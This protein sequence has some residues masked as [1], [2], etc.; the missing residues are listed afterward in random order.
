MP[1][2]EFNVF[3]GHTMLPITA[4]DLHSVRDEDLLQVIERLD[5]S[6]TQILETGSHLL[7]R[8]MPV[9]ACYPTVEHPH[10]QWVSYLRSPID[11]QIIPEVAISLFHILFRFRGLRNLAAFG[12]P[13]GAELE[14]Q[15]QRMVAEPEVSPPRVPLT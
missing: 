6:H 7:V 15:R 1:S 11:A 13:T 4:L 5:A 8:G 3:D 10:A 2:T 9:Y 14:A 12:F